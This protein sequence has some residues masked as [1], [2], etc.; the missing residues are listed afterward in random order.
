MKECKCPYNESCPH[1]NRIPVCH[2]ILKSLARKI[3]FLKKAGLIMTSEDLCWHCCNK[4][5]YPDCKPEMVETD[6]SEGMND[7][8]RCSNYNV[9]LEKKDE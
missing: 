8:I 5:H 3:Y 1:N 7:I 9:Q 2:I 4:Q 6:N